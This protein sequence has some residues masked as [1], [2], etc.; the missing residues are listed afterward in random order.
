MSINN[1]VILKTSKYK[2]KD[3]WWFK[4]LRPEIATIIL[5]ILVFFVNVKLSP[6]FADIGFILD[7]S[8]IYIEFGIIAISMTFIIITGNIDLSVTSI[9]ALVGC[10]TGLMYKAGINM[11]VSITLGLL[12]GILLG[13]LNGLFIVKLKLPSIIVTIGTMSLYRGIA[14]ILLGDHSVGKFPEWFVGIDRHFIGIIPVP[15]CIFSILV[16]IFGFILN[17]TVFGRNVY[18]IGTNNVCAFYSCVPV[19]S[20]VMGLFCLSGFL[21]A[22][23]GLFMISRLGVARFDMAFGGELDIITIVLLGGVSINGGKG[24]IFGPTIAFFLLLIMRTGMSVANIKIENQL[25][26]IGSLLCI[27]VIITNLVN[28]I[29]SRC[30][31]KKLIK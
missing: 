25:T 7:F 20:I 11:Y 30:S 14:Q 22:I 1:S 31:R 15:L 3:Q 2:K 23:G 13:F 9:M 27:S 6:Y 19:D 16:I 24:N 17:Y 10:A 21:S 28:N 8:S 18:A 4:L 26:I 5:F 12:L 29:H